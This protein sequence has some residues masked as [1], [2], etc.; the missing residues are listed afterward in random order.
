MTVFVNET[1]FGQSKEERFWIM[2]RF[3]L[4]TVALSLRCTELAEV[5]KWGVKGEGF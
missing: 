2:C 3:P 1:V 4:L 5:S